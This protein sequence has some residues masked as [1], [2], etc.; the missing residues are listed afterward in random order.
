MAKQYYDRYNDFR[1]NNQ[2]KVLPFIK[3]K[4]RDTDINI[5][6]KKNRTR[7]DIVSNTYYGTPY[8]GWLI[9]QANSQYGSLEFD[10]P[11]GAVLRVPFPLINA[12]QD[13]EQSI[14]NYDVL[15]KIDS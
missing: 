10:I 5:E 3:I 8:Y 9:L 12:L 1:I 11:E 4:Q 7:L 2:V 14:K 15:Y 6:Y 13:Y